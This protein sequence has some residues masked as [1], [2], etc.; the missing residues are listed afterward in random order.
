[1]NTNGQTIDAATYHHASVKIR[2][3]GGFGLQDF[4]G[5]MV[6]RFVWQFPGWSTY[7]V[8][9]AFLSTT[10]SRTYS[11]DLK[12]QPPTAVLEP[13]NSP[14]PVGWG[15][16]TSPPVSLFR[17]DPHED[18]AERNWHIDEIRLARNDRVAPRF[19]VR[20]ADQA[21]EAGTTAQIYADSDRNTSNGL[22][23][24]IA[25]GL[26]VNQ[27]ENQFSWDGRGVSSGSYW[28]Y[29]VMTDPGGGAAG[30]YGTGQLD[31]DGPPPSIPFG[32]LDM[33][34]GAANSVVVG[35]WAID[36]DT[37][38]PIDVHVYV[39][40]RGFNLGQASAS[41]ADVAGL[42]PGYGA[43]HGFNASLS[44]ISS[45]SH[46]VCAYGINVGAGSTNQLGCRSLAV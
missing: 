45:G 27:G 25:S 4:G 31:V 2:Y 11:M 9:D 22:G 17:F 34:V 38:A 29:V 8:G 36:P 33:A 15:A 3:D 32:S 20:F 16:P 10:A 13:E 21:W 28:I 42:F 23:A 44:G 40:G 26:I 43:S 12:T 41:R 6:T 24:R 39:D 5:G 7:Q 35:G 18:M 1:M 46:L 19:S 37:D 14:T 30:S